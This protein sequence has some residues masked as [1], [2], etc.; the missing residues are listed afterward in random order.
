MVLHR[1]GLREGAGAERG[2]EVDASFFE[3]LDREF[4]GNG[5]GDCATAGEPRFLVTVE[6]EP[7][8]PGR[9]RSAGSRSL[10]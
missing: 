9:R 1:M 8:S 5:R 2:L 6:V 10:S 7:L 3:N 4:P